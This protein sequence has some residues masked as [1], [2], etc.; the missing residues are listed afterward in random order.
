MHL[1]AGHL[2]GLCQVSWSGGA[3]AFQGASQES[4]EGSTGWEWPCQ[5]LTA[6]PYLVNQPGDE[7]IPG[8]EGDPREE[9]SLGPVPRLPGVL[10][11]GGMGQLED[12][13]WL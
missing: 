4:L 2:R 1:R 7:K 5:S 12:T 3:P 9:E 13:Q 11:K 10:G 8:L 6:F